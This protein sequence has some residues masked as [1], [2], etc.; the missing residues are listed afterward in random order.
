VED[1]T[2]AEYAIT[3]RYLILISSASFS[4]ASSTVA[5]RSC[6]HLAAGLVRN[7]EF[8]HTKC[9]VRVTPEI[10]ERMRVASN[11]T[12]KPAAMKD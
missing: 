10:M 12:R 11:I 9:G 2:G 4:N 7:A 5:F 1:R 6:G 8:L 3:N